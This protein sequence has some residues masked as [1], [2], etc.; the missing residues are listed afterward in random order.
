ITVDASGPPDDLQI[1][2]T[3]SPPLN[4]E[5][6]ISLLYIRRRT[7]EDIGSLTATNE[8]VSLA[9]KLNDDLAGFQSEVQEYFGFENLVLEPDFTDASRSGTLKLRAE[10]ML[11]RDLKAT[12]STSLSSTDLDFWLGYGFTENMLLDFGWNSLREQEVEG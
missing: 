10:K 9:I 8:A 4:R 5:D 12:L 3:S 7:S 1:D 2:L 11:R 6:I